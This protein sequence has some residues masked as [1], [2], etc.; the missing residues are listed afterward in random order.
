MTLSPGT[1]LGPYEV[2]ALLGK[3]GMGEVYRATDTRLGRT[4]ALKVLPEDFLESEEKKQRFEREARVLA[5]LNHPG[6]AAIYSFEEIPGSSSSASSVSR[7][8]L[9]MELVEGKG[10]DRVIPKTGLPLPQF[11]EIAIALADALSAAHQKGITHR[12]LKPANVMVTDDGHVKILDFGLARVVDQES[13]SGETDETLQKLTHAGTI[14][15]TIPYMSPEQVEARPLDHRTDIF[16]LGV[17]LYEMA[18]GGRPFSGDS[19]PALMSS[20]LRDEPKPLSRLRP[21]MPDGLSRLVG[22]CLEKRPGD[23]IQTASEILA[24][25]KALCRAHESGAGVSAPTAG[26]SSGAARPEEGFWVAVLPYKHRGTDPSLE[27]L[28]DGMT[29][30]IVTGLSRFSYLRVVSRSSMSRY[31]NA[32][33]D[34][35][36]VGKEIGARYVMEGS[37]RHAGAQLR[38][39]VQLVDA[40]T[41]AHLWAETYD[42]P[43]SAADI[44]AI[45]DDLVPRIVSTCADHFGVLARSIS[46]AVRGREAGRLSPYDALMR[47]FGYHHRLTPVEHAEAREAL[48][49]AVQQ[50]PANADCWAMLSWIY[51]HE[52]A[53]GFNVRPGSLERALAAARRAVDIAPSNHLAQQALAVVLFFRKETASCLSA[54]ERAIALNPLDGSN[55]AIFLITFS[56]EWERGCTLIRRAMDLNPHHPRWY[57]VVLAMNEYR[58]AHYRAAVDEIVKANAPDVFWTN[59]LLAAAH[60][61]LGELT[62]ARTALQDLLSQKED[63][64]QSAGELMGKWFEPQMAGHLM[65]GLRKAGLDVPV[66]ARSGGA[67]SARDASVAIAV[68]PFADMSAAKDQEYLCEGMAEEIMNALVRVD[69]IRVA[70]RTSAFRAGRDGGDL[71]AIARALSVGHVLEGSVRTAGPRIRVTARLTDAAA[72]FQVWSEKFDRDVTDVFA[73]QDE[74]AAGVV[75]AVRSRLAPGQAALQPRPQ[76]RNLEAY[77]HFL[78]GRHLRFTKNDHGSALIS[79]ERAVALDPSYGPSWVALADIHVLAAAY[80]MRPSSEAISAAKAELL[81]ADRL[82]GETGDARY[83]EGMIAFC[84]RRWAD[85]DRAIDRA[86]QIEPGNV[87]AHCWSGMLL[88]IR[89]RTEEAI[90]ALE[91][92]R[93]LDPL[94]PYPY[95]MT[96]FCLLSLRR[97]ADAARFAGQALAFDED[98]LLALWVSGAADVSGARFDQAVSRL[99]RA[100]ARARSNPFTQGTLGWVL[101]AAGRTSEAHGVLEALRARAVPGATV[102]SEAWL[103]AAL[104]DADGAFE[105]LRRACDEKQLLVPFIGMPGLDPLR[106]DP[107]F[108]AFV[109]KLGLAAPR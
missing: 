3:G 45:Q 42:R 104:G 19:S 80:G 16:S 95:A 32:A 5:S 55:E 26:A 68:L 12:D 30:E 75:E 85:A 72:G 71:A 9:V 60:G 36:A 20:I 50:A 63:F 46:D 105:V 94:A 11:F 38:V 61:E 44:F 81:T 33:V 83:V 2:L 31:A 1:R 78:M 40:S 103:L 25:L 39:T 52:H 96:G 48:E 106:S 69:G 87:Q 92:A 65:E 89:G 79:L 13:G 109:E 58:M 57:G 84:E 74:I 49:R 28:A 22:R 91:R 23:R 90:E 37:L 82:Q 43:F 27:A 10:L 4:V 93:E 24:E 29:E 53:H 35:R 15:G 97:A 67:P 66:P 102:V 108:P 59:A 88:S 107:R 73:V 41:G 18:T 76:L 14:V 70:S 34:V 56:G 6:I 77:Q 7:H 8:L 101:A 54:A 21:E 47:G 64:A 17:V 99:E 86:M 100:A 98:N 62:A 51:S